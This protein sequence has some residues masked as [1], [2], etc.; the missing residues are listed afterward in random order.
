MIRLILL[1][2]LLLAPAL[3]RADAFRVGYQK[4]GTLVVVRQQHRLEEA[5]APTGTTVDWVEFQSGPTLLE[6]LNA[7]A[8]DAGYTGDSPPVFAQAAGV[9][10]VYVARLNVGGSD[11]GLLVRKDSPIQALADLRGKRIAFTKGSSA[12]YMTVKVLA[13]AGMTLADVHP[14]F[15]TP[16]DGRAAFRAGSVDAWAIWDPF[17]AVGQE[18]ADARTLTDGQ[19][20]PSSSFLLARRPYAHD[21]PA[22]IATWL[23]VVNEAAAWSELHQGELARTMAEIT[24]VDLPAERVAAARGTYHYDLLTDETVARQ[25]GVA[26]TFA[27]LR[28]IPRRIAVRE[29]VWTPPKDSSPKDAAP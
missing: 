8:I 2:L 18:D 19:V 27:D 17:F 24:G 6:A 16:A 12:H 13:A 23:R 5:L 10:F 11:E 25:Q 1:G 4:T 22:T 3:A 9:D 7:G 29:N 15:L 26:D 14:V 28:I 20:A 21:H